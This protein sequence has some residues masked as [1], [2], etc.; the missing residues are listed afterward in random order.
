[1]NSQR[2]NW[3]VTMKRY[4]AFTLVELLVVIAVIALLMAILLPALNRAKEQGKRVACMSNIKQLTTAWGMYADACNDKIVNTATP[5]EGSAECDQC[6]D[7]PTGDPYIA[8]ARAPGPANVLHNGEMPWV[9]GAFYSYTQPLV[10]EAAKCAIQTGALFK[11]VPEFKLFRCPTANKGEFFTYNAM[12]SMNGGDT[13]GVASLKPLKNRNQIKHTA[14]RIVFCDEGK[15]TPNVFAL[16]DDIEQWWDPPEIR[17]GDGQVFSFADNHAEY[18]KWS[19]ESVELGRRYI[20]GAYNPSIMRYSPETDA[21]K[22]D[23]YRIQLR[24]WGK[25]GYTPSVRVTVD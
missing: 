19:K 4:K 7:C 1:L 5:S 2:V 24:C 15:V 20:S 9:G 8:K 16:E 14:K 3:G 25:L 10:E 11:Y 23:L 12:A 22:Q 6:P 13:S 18:W 21:G 17:H